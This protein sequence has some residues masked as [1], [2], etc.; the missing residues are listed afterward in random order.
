L[1]FVP[2]FFTPVLVRLAEKQPWRCWLGYGSAGMPSLE[3]I[4]SATL[5]AAELL[6]WPNAVGA[7]EPGKYADLI[8]VEGDPLKDITE[9]L[10]VR[11]VMKG[12]K[13]AR[14]DLRHH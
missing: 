10:R 11:F 7:I 3:V 2:T 6:G 12:G 8:A 13:V 9:L 4:R 5:N 14:D 1:L